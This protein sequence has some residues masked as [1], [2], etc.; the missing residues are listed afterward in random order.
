MLP[1]TRVARQIHVE[2]HYQVNTK[3]TL[4]I[5]ALEMFDVSGD[6][7]VRLETIASNQQFGSADDWPG[8][9]PLLLNFIRLVETSD[10]PTLVEHEGNGASNGVS[11]G[12]KLPKTAPESAQ[13]T[14]TDVE[15]NDSSGDVTPARSRLPNENFEGP[16]S[17]EL[18][19]KIL[20]HI[21]G[22]FKDS[23]PFTVVRMAE[24]ITRPQEEGYSRKNVAKWMRLMARLALVELSVAEYP[25]VSFGGSPDALADMKLV[26]IPWA[27]QALKRR[28]AE[29]EEKEGGAKRAKGE[30][31]SEVESEAKEK[32]ENGHK[33]VVKAEDTPNEAGDGQAIVEDEPE[34]EKE[35]SEPDYLA[36]LTDQ[37]EASS[38]EQKSSDDIIEDK[39]EELE[40]TPPTEEESL[41]S[42]VDAVP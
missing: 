36:I 24:I 11:N 30:G 12:K 31:D 23:P 9:K 19:K 2:L 8:L 34:A 13:D 33:D 40:K 42:P 27:K 17:S 20:A 39:P 14:P 18:Q 22:S 5:K 32:A 38:A 10:D 37:A 7:R 35:T 1:T 6:L 25:Q 21:E 28:L 26:E 15:Q 41:P 4:P 16:A 29:Q 3:P